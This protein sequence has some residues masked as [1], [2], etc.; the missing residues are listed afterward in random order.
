MTISFMSVLDEGDSGACI[1]GNN[2]C[3]IDAGS[4]RCGE[5]H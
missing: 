1:T 2:C 3:N 4:N 5:H